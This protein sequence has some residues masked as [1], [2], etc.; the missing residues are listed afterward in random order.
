M[1]ELKTIIA[2]R[3]RHAREQAGFDRKTVSERLGEGFSVPAISAHEIGRNNLKPDVIRKYAMLYKASVDWLSG[4]DVK[5]RR[6]GTVSASYAK[7][8]MDAPFV[9]VAEHESGFDAARQLSVGIYDVQIAAGDGAYIDEAH[10]TGEV[11]F[12][13]QWLRSLTD[14]PPS[15]LYMVQLRG[16]SMHDTLPDGS[17]VIIDTLATR[18]IDNK[19]YAFRYDDEAKIK[20]I[21]IH[22]QTKTLTLISDN[23]S[24]PD[25]SGVDPEALDVLG[26]AIWFSKKL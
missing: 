3:L 2:H 13:E 25:I 23:P 17:W 10:R 24:W 21:S 1:L 8:A 6:D 4:V 14:T 7:I 12:D 9:G 26:R 5:T 16:D 11:S 20:R 22:P 19:I 18:L 15:K